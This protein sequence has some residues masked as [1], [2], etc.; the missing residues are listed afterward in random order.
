MQIILSYKGGKD[1]T[2]WYLTILVMINILVLVNFD[3]EFKDE[4]LKY[5]EDGLSTNNLLFFF[6]VKTCYCF[7]STNNLVLFLFFLYSEYVLTTFILQ[8]Y[9]SNTFA[10]QIKMN[11]FLYQKKSLILNLKEKNKQEKQT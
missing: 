5:Y 7:L 11:P 3:Y 2:S 10:K 1:I 8:K 4:F 9:S 6:L